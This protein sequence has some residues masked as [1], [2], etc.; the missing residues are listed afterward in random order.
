MLMEWLVYFYY[1]TSSKERRDDEEKWKTLEERQTIS[2]DDK[3]SIGWTN[4]VYE[5][6]MEDYG[7]TESDLDEERKKGMPFLLCRLI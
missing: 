6:M 4:R 7:L 1:K 3:K 2:Y 5:S